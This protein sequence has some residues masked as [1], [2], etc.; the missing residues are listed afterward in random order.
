MSLKVEA[1]STMVL[2]AYIVPPVIIFVPMV[3][4]AITKPTVAKKA[5]RQTII[6]S[7]ADLD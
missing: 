2:V 6:T 1:P 5:N 4:A 7:Q 3:V